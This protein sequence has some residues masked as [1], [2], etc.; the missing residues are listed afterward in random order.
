MRKLFF[1]IAG[2]AAALMAVSCNTP[3][4]P[5]DPPKKEVVF[6]KLQERTIAS[7]A[8]VD[9]SFK[10]DFA[11]E[12]SMPT[13]MSQW[14]YFDDNGVK[15]Y[16]IKGKAGSGSVKVVSVEGME[17]RDVI[18]CPLTMVMEGK[19]AVIAN[20]SLMP[21]E[22]TILVYAAATD[23]SGAYIPVGGGE[24]EYQTTPAQTLNLVWPAGMQSYTLPIKVVANFNWSLPET[25]PDWMTVTKSS[26]DQD[27][28]VT[29]MLKG[30][31]AHYPLDDASG[32]I[33]FMDTD[34]RSIAF[35][36]PVK[37]TGCKDIV[38][39]DGASSTTQ[40]NFLGQ[41]NYNDTWDS[42]GCAIRV[43]GTK[44]VDIVA[45][46]NRA[47]QLSYSENTWVTVSWEESTGTDV[48]IDRTAYISA[49]EN[50]D[51][52]RDAYLLALPGYL[53][54]QV[55]SGA[56]DLI[57]ANGKAIKSEYQKYVFTQVHQNGGSEGEWGVI[58]PLNTTYAMA[59]VGGGVSR[60]RKDDFLYSILKGLYNTDELYCVDYN[61][62]ASDM[63]ADLASFVD[64]TS[65]TYLNSNVEQ[66]SSLD[67]VELI[68]PVPSDLRSFR[69][70]INLFE[71]G[72]SCG[73]ILKDN[74][75]VIAIIWCRMSSAYWPVCDYN[76]IYFTMYDFIS[77]EDDPDHQ[78]LPSDA[79]LEEIKDGEVY[80]LYKEYNI[81]VW[82]LT[83]TSQY[84]ARNA[85]IYVPP[86]QND[87]EDSIE[88]CP[89][90]FDSSIS[91]ES[92]SYNISGVNKP[93]VHVR[94][95]DK[96]A[97]GKEGY[98]VLKGAG[99]PVFVLCVSLSY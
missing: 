83:Y 23:N 71:D 77:E 58:A 5:I 52:D 60:M 43:T 1:Y 16:K 72:Y 6:P 42:K 48:V 59:T 65:V 8:S 11:W 85:M 28:A 66:R 98:I 99:R 86:F 84:A 20:I 70:A 61:N 22:R 3:V 10:V 21:E 36:I 54:K 13:N 29:L 64:F 15:S 53:V 44:D 81:P 57:A 67:E 95:K 40:L 89:A 12:V 37:I 39:V 33:S 50:T 27:E 19:S 69:L 30:V 26:G 46:H 55:R 35:E 63:Y 7:G 51:E 87:V 76:K 18:V 96:L 75:K 78:M 92:G 56:L 80:D 45:I 2:V 88:I 97:G 38:F 41:Y 49:L 25:Y 93:Y 32:K 31:P 9:I 82:K 91:V 62:A 17:V 68:N 34:D 74:G 79:F 47:G 73:A 94:M 90:G 4:D 14:F 24:F